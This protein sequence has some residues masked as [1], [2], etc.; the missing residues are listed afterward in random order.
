MNNS[1]FSTQID[2]DFKTGLYGDGIRF[3]SNPHNVY[4]Y[5]IITGVSYNQE[6]NVLIVKNSSDEEITISFEPET[7]LFKKIIYEDWKEWDEKYGKL[8]EDRTDYKPLCHN[9][10]KSL[11]K[12]LGLY[13]NEKMNYKNMYI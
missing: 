1:W 13:D 5:E 4:D 8:D 9:S 7:Q 3:H 11:A 10:I 2:R 6:T 12:E